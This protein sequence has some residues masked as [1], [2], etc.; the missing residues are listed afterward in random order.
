MNIQ[1]Q[2]K[3][4]L[5]TIYEAIIKILSEFDENFMLGLLTGI[6]V[7]S[8]VFY[9]FW[10]I[11]RGL[12]YCFDV[13]LS[14]F[15]QFHLVSVDLFFALIPLAYYALRFEKNNGKRVL[16]AL[17]FPFLVFSLHD[18]SWLIETHFIPQVYLNGMTMN[19]ATFYEYVH[20]YSKNLVNI[21]PTMAI[22]L[23]FKFFKVNKKFLIAFSGFVAFHL[24]NIVFQVNIYILNGLALLIMETIDA[25]PYLFLIKKGVSED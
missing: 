2:L 25:I 15:G 20:H 9:R 1:K 4:T 16:G 12:L 3:P 19:G 13:A 14:P 6:M 17:L 21:I 18:I 10:G 22:F 11:P 8:M 5:T 24:I 23:K 7:V